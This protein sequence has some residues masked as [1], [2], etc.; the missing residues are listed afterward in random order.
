MRRFV[1]DK[2]GEG[3]TGL[4]IALLLISLFAAFAVP[5]LWGFG[6]ALRLDGEAAQLATE[7]MRYRETVIT[8]LPVHEDFLGVGEETQPKFELNADGYGIRANGK[9]VFWHPLPKDIELICRSK[10]DFRMTGNAQPMTIVLQSGKEVR[11]VNID[12]VGR[13]RVSLT[14]PPPQE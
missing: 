2:R 4:L 10:V 6:T 1:W 5:R 3:L 12:V 14:P 8:R 7:L 11:Y 13:V 9:D